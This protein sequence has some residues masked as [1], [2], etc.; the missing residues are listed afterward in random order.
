MLAASNFSFSYSVFKSLVLQTR[1]KTGLVWEKVKKSMFQKKKYL[2]Q[3]MSHLPTM[4]N[5]QFGNFLLNLL[6]VGDM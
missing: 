6:A 1:K 5:L 3:A 4:V 2:L